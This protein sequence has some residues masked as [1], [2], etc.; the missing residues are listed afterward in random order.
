MELKVGDKITRYMSDEQIPIP[1]E[2]FAVDDDYV[3]LSN[4]VMTRKDQCWKFD[5][6]CGYEVDEGLGRME[7][8]TVLTSSYIP[9]KEYGPPELLTRDQLIALKLA[10]VAKR[11]GVSKETALSL[12]LGFTDRPE[13][14]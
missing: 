4:G 5:K 1:A 2:V 7:D 14:V 13:G 9:V 12:I 3:Y 8:G 6:T 10:A 11:D